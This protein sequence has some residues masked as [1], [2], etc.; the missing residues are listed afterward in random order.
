MVA[1]QSRAN[2]FHRNGLLGWGAIILC[3]SATLFAF[4][5]LAAA[6]TDA[7]VRGSSLLTPVL[8]WISRFLIVASGFV[9]IAWLKT[10][11]IVEDD[12]VECRTLS[13]KIIVSF[14]AVV[15]IRETVGGAYFTSLLG[16]RVWVPKTLPGY[17]KMMQQ[18]CMAIDKNGETLAFWRRESAFPT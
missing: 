15:D 5:W 11:Y 16:N 17:E 3:V 14:D 7:Y 12:R 6:S 4:F 18:A 10:G 2:T 1:Q 9:G 8:A 13:Q